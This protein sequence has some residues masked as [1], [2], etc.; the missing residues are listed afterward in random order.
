MNK[1]CPLR[2]SGMVPCWKER[3]A[4]YLVHNKQCAIPLYASNLKGIHDI[5]KVVA[6]GP[7]KLTRQVARRDSKYTGG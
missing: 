4:W 2:A 6:K 1:W 5:L 3:C 7:V